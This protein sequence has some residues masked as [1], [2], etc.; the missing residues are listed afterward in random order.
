MSGQWKSGSSPLSFVLTSGSGRFLSIERKAAS[1]RLLSPALPAA[2]SSSAFSRRLQVVASVGSAHRIARRAF[3]EPALELGLVDHVREFVR[4]QDVGEVHERPG[5]RGHRDALVRRDVARV[6]R[7]AS[8]HAHTVSRRRHLGATTSMRE[9]RYLR[10]SQ[11]SAAARWLSA[12]PSPAHSTAARNVA[13]PRERHMPDRVHPASHSMQTSRRHAPRDRLVIQARRE[14]LRH[15]SRARAD[16]PPTAAITR[17]PRG[18]VRSN[19]RLAGVS[20]DHPPMIE[21]CL[22]ADLRAIATN[23]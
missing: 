5:D 12:A 8:M 13:L 11:S 18:V 7:R 17:P 9:A 2:L 14:Q 15:A 22:R 19:C 23:L 3:A 10:T 4:V 16:A 6:Q 21:P 1:L 20:V